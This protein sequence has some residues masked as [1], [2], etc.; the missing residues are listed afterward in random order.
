MGGTKVRLDSRC[1]PEQVVGVAAEVHLRRG[2]D[3]D[4]ADHQ[5]PGRVL[6]DV[7]QDF[8]ERLAVEE[9]RLDLDP[10]VARQGLRHPQVR[11]VDLGQAGVDDL[12]VQLFL[13]FEAKDLRRLG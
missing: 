12:F 11:L 2:V 6:A 9:R 5:Q 7:L 1:Q 3:A 4:P 13:L 10:L 8:L